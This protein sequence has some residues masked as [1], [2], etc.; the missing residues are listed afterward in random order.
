MNK[1]FF[2][3][4]KMWAG[5]LFKAFMENDIT[6]EKELTK[7]FPLTSKNSMKSIK[8]VYKK[9]KKQGMT[10]F[11]A[12]ILHNNMELCE[13]LIEE[14]IDLGKEGSVMLAANTRLTQF[15]SDAEALVR[16]GPNSNVFKD[17]N[18]TTP[19]F[20]AIK[21][22]KL[23][24][25]EKLIRSGHKMN[26]PVER[27]GGMPALSFAISN[28]NIPIVTY[29][30]QNQLC[31]IH[32]NSLPDTKPLDL[33]INSGSIA[34][35]ELLLKQG[36]EIS[37]CPNHKFTPLVQ[38]VLQNNV[39]IV[40]L[41]LEM[42]ADINFGL[43]DGLCL[44]PLNMAIRRQHLEI[45]SFLIKK[46]A[47]VTVKDANGNTALHLL[48]PLIEIPTMNSFSQSS[49]K[50]AELLLEKGARIDVANE[51]GMTPL[52]IAI[53]KCEP[54]LVDLVLSNPVDL[55][56]RS[57]HKPNLTILHVAVSHP[58]KIGHQGVVVNSMD[59]WQ[60]RCSIVKSLI[61]KGADVNVQS[62]D[63]KTSLHFAAESGCANLVN[64][65]LESKVDINKAS[66]D[67]KV[68]LHYAAYSGSFEVVQ[69][70]LQSDAEVNAKDNVGSTPLDYGIMENQ[71]FSYN[72]TKL[73]I[74]YGVDIYS[75][76]I[77]GTLKIYDVLVAMM[78]TNL[79]KLFWRQ[80]Y[81]Y[82]LTF[83]QSND[84]FAFMQTIFNNIGFE[85]VIY[86]DFKKR[87]IYLKHLEELMNTQSKFIN[88]IK[89][90]KVKLVINALEKGAEVRGSSIEVPFPL[91]FLA[92]NGFT[93]VAE[94]LLSRGVKPNTVD[95]EGKIP[96]DLALE[97]GHFNMYV[98][99]LRNGACYIRSGFEKSILQKEGKGEFYNLYLLIKEVFKSVKHGNHSAFEHLNK[100]LMLKPWDFYFAL[101]NCVD[102]NGHTL[103]SWAVTRG[104]FTISQKLMEYRLQA[105]QATK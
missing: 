19:M 31:D 66:K 53:V 40:R 4:R 59:Y 54:V 63:G 87:E 97:F 11:I 80:G 93:E 28:K 73:F 29:F 21:C 90:N 39:S 58:D 64:L 32:E 20:W 33:A 91:H 94:V 14:G 57:N 1:L 88:G 37:A 17:F 23:S 9:C 46:G 86:K 69:M 104:D 60:R 65:L 22:E 16:L 34:M 83:F 51:K 2:C 89:E 56:T 85:N 102:E 61:K 82:D 67:G 41:F 8:K 84:S 76:C 10:P 78:R 42:G 3:F 81:P 79:M 18:D 25:V 105:R 38:A 50:L 13:K 27:V 100:Y 95:S 72:C 55:N 30:L 45:A 96:I 35:M 52:L 44:P 7:Y 48:L 98:A 70:L 15:Y 36:G 49:F 5:E 77:I 71:S 62:E 12:A 26:S 47:D 24:L 92:K 68:A 99:L 74:D 101:V 6:K 43:R 103:M 75:H